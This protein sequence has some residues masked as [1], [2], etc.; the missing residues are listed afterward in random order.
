MVLSIVNVNCFAITD[1]TAGHICLNLNLFR[2]HRYITQFCLVELRPQGTDNTQKIRD[3]YRSQC[4]TY[5]Y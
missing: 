3:L 5:S 4:S 1:E 2:I